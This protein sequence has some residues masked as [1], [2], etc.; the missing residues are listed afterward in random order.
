MTDGLTVTYTYTTTTDNGTNATSP[1]VTY[2]D[3]GTGGTN[4]QT[5]YGVPPVR[6]LTPMQ[7][8]FRG[9]GMEMP[10]GSR[11][12]NF[13]RDHARRPEVQVLANFF[14]QNLYEQF[15]ETVES[16]IKRI[17]INRPKRE[18]SK[19]KVMEIL[20]DCKEVAPAE[21]VE[22]EDVIL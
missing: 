1:W 3:P 16:E 13:I 14:Y 10:N 21:E 17:Q 7:L 12:L 19:Y 15:L 6:E 5:T 9:R 22:L 4:Y 20:R 18:S 2:S 8:A 11:V